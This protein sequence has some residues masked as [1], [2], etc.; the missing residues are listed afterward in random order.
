MTAL[1]QVNCCKYLGI[2]IDNN[3]TCSEHNDYANIYNKILKFTSIFYKIRHVLPYNVF[4]TIYFV[5]LH[6]HL[7][8]GIKIYGNT[9]CTHLNKCKK[10]KFISPVN[11]V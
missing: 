8:Y 6:S 4:I 3:L 5:F 2:I 9:H 7:L 1:K 10:R 11:Y